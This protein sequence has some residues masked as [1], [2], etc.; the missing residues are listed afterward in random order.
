MTSFIAF[1]QLTSWLVYMIKTGFLGPIC[2]CVLC[3]D[4][5]LS[6]DEMWKAVSPKAYG[7]SFA[8]PVNQRPI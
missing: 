2:F 5:V 1:K 7:L 8:V 3:T 6:G 4:K